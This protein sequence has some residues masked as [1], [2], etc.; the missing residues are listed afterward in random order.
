MLLHEAN[1][2]AGC[3]AGYA[4]VQY[5]FYGKKLVA[6]IAILFNMKLLVDNNVH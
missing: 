5:T 6:M 2:C 3:V 1:L 4:G